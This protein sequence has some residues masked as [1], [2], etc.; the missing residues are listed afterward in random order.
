MNSGDILGQSRSLR[1]YRA[2]CERSELVFLDNQTRRNDTGFQANGDMGKLI[3]GLLGWD[4]L[5]PGSRWRC[6]RAL[7][8][9]PRRRPSRAR[10]THVDG[11]GLRRR[12]PALVAPYRGL[13]RGSASVP[14]GGAAE[15]WHAEHER[16]LVNRRP[17]ASVGLVW[18]QENVDFFGRE[19]PEERV[20]APYWGMAQALIRARIPYVPV[21]AEDI[22]TL[23][24]KWRPEGRGSFR[25]HGHVKRRW[26]LCSHPAQRGRALGGAS[27]CGAVLRSG[28]WG[29][30]RY[31]SDRSL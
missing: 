15:R 20:M 16:H 18:S 10:G 9:L 30:D 19:A 24:D 27:R 12:H 6:T 22:G 3:H 25:P 5:V 1:D 14:D 17:V 21:H 7:A 26:S 29:P 13:P 4:K 11:R 31:G 23:Y 2:I 28:G 8:D